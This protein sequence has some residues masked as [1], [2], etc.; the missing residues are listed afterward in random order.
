MP[1]QAHAAAMTSEWC[2]EQLSITKTEF[3]P[4]KGVHLGNTKLIIK[5]SNCSILIDPQ[6]NTIDIYLSIVYAGNIDYFGVRFSNCLTITGH[7][8]SAQLLRLSPVRSF[9]LD[10]SINTNCQVLNLDNWIIQVSQSSSLRQAA[11]DLLTFE[12]QLICFNVQ[13]IVNTQAQIQCS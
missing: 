11:M 2:I 5:S 6:N 12:V 3:R 4:R 9:A 1:S 7:P 10:S 13:D 8:L